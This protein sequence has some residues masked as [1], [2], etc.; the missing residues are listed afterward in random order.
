MS[1]DIMAL[2]IVGVMTVAGA[3]SGAR[4]QVARLLAALLAY[5]IM[6]EYNPGFCV[7]VAETLGLSFSLLPFLCGALMWGLADSLCAAAF[8][9][10]ARLGQGEDLT[11]D[12]LDRLLGALLGVLKGAALVLVGLSFWGLL[13]ATPHFAALDAKHYKA[14][15]QLLTYA[16]DGP[17]KGWLSPAAMLDDPRLK[18]FIAA[19]AAAAQPA[20]RPLRTP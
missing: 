2:V 14:D 5:V 1:I 13:T 10:I 9:F 15:S 17:L 16:Q 7:W 3:Y 6:R 11:H 18:G 12:A 8:V 20:R 19:P 4:V